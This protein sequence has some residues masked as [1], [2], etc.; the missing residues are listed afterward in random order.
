MNFTARV[1]SNQDFLEDFVPQESDAARRGEDRF[2]EASDGV[3]V[4][5][6]SEITEWR[7]ICRRFSIKFQVQQQ[8]TKKRDK[9]LR[10]K[11]LRK[12]GSDFLR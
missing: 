5:D 3:A 4:F 11:L 9:I 12:E 6:R 7:K 10:N 2:R 1:D 8:K